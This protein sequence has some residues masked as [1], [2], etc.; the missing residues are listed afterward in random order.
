[1]LL[2]VETLIILQKKLEL[3]NESSKLS[4]YKINM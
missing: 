4:E 2:Y 1:M 3:I